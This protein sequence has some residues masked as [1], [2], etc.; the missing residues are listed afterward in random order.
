[1]LFFGILSEDLDNY[2]NAFEFFLKKPIIYCFW[3]DAAV[4]YFVLNLVISLSLKFMS[5]NVCKIKDLFAILLSCNHLYCN[6]V[7]MFFCKINYSQLPAEVLTICKLQKNITI[8]K[9]KKKKDGI[10]RFWPAW[11][12]YTFCL[13]APCQWPASSHLYVGTPLLCSAYV[14]EHWLRA[15]LLYVTC[16]QKTKGKEQNRHIFSLSHA[17]H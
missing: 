14:K 17:H 2:I 16:T 6:W 10:F 5:K 15:L 11:G 7:S 9:K 12:Q 4:D 3:K 13:W 1:M 8:M